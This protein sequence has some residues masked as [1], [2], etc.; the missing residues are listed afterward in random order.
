MKHPT[1]QRLKGPP[2]SHTFKFIPTDSIQ[3]HPT[4]LPVPNLVLPPSTCQSYITSAS[5]TPSSN[6]PFLD[7]SNRQ[8]QT[9]L[10]LST[11]C[12][13]EELEYSSSSSSQTEPVAL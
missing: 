7:I 9:S 2:Q 5:S 4:S 8:P 1:R 11:F 12:L 10:P 6:Q 3:S 13:P